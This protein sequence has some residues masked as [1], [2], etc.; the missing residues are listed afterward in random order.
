M[1]M[2]LKHSS[3]FPQSL[4]EGYVHYGIV[5]GTILKMYRNGILIGSESSPT[6]SLA[7]GLDKFYL[8]LY[9]VPYL[10]LIT[11]VF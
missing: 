9:V 2:S 3:H 5:F 4:S 1:K 10:R 8:G 6:F 7:T 11:L